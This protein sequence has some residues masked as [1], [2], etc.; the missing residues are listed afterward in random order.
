MIVTTKTDKENHG[1]GL[2]SIKR[3]IQ[4]YKGLCE[5]SCKDNIFSINITLSV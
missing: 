3:T 5:I 4:K 1:L 2:Y